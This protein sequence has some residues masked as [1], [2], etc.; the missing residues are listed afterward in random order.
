MD[1]YFVLLILLFVSMSQASEK[2]AKRK[3]SLTVPLDS[4]ANIYQELINRGMQATAA[5]L[6]AR[7][8]YVEN[9][10]RAKKAHDEN[11]KTIEDPQ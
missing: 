7:R 10:V 11:N 1:L 8:I 5:D 3:V 9:L 6:Q 4:L 2:E